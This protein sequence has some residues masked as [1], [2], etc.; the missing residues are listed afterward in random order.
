[1]AG[2]AVL[3]RVTWRTATVMGLRDEQR[4]RE[5]SPLRCVSGRVTSPVSTLTCA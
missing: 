3:G 1:M 5:R 2:T 4:P